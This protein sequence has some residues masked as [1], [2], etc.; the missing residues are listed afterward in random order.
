MN[1]YIDFGN[2]WDALSA[3]G[4]IGAV[5]LSLWLATR[6]EKVKFSVSLSGA[7]GIQWD[8]NIDDSPYLFV[9]PLNKSKFPLTIEEVGFCHNKKDT[10]RLAVLDQRYLIEGSDTIS[11]RVEPL[12]T[13]KYVFELDKIKELAKKTWGEN[14]E[15]RAY[16]RDTTKK[17][18]YS[19][20]IKI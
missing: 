12:E 13:A 4:T 8:N 11:K 18:H 16:V 14:I 1:I 17:S 15:I 5:A 20:K 6:A 3:V 19:K 10:K 2:M 7:L 9:E